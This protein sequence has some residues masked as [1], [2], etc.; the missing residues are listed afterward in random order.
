MVSSGSEISIVLRRRGAPR[1]FRILVRYFFILSAFLLSSHQLAHSQSADDTIGSEPPLDTL[2]AALMIGGNG[3]FE[4]PVAVRTNASGHILVLDQGQNS[5]LVCDYDGTLLGQHVDMG[6][7]QPNLSSPRDMAVDQRSWIYIAD[8]KNNR[9]VA[10][11]DVGEF[12]FDIALTYDVMTIDVFGDGNIYAQSD[13]EHSSH[14][15]DIYSPQ[16]DMLKSVGALWN[17]GLGRDG[18]DRALN[19][20]YATSVPET[21]DLI[22][23]RQGI[24]VVS[25]TNTDSPESRS[26][27]V[28]TPEVDSTRTRYFYSL[29]DAFYHNQHSPQPN[30][31]VEDYITDIENTIVDGGRPTIVQYIAGAEYFDGVLYLLVMV[32]SIR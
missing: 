19:R 30:P 13:A 5:V 23:A 31:D 2:I 26:F 18:M 4:R 15:I 21:D 27:Q 25:I 20:Y 16:G 10:L 22:I 1:F 28:S 32:E 7:Q 11:D 9:I 12:K 6:G 17:D 29:S 3:L 8:T 14:L 24:P